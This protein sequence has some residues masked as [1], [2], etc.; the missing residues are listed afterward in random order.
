MGEVVGDA[1]HEAGLAF[2]GHTDNGDHARAKLTLGVIHKPAQILGRNVLQR[3][4]KELHRPKIADHRGCVGRR[5]PAKGKLALGIGELFFEL[6]ALIEKGGEPLDHLV[7][8]DFEQLRSLAHAGVLRGEIRACPLPSQRLDAADA[9]GNRA[10]AHDLEQADI[11]GAPHMGAAAKLDGI[12]VISLRAR[13]ALTHADDTDLF[14]IFLTEQRKR[15]FGDRL[16]GAHQMR[17]H[18]GVL[19]YHGVGKIFHRLDLGLRHRPRMGEVEAKPPRLDQRAL[20]GHVQPKHFAQRFVQEV[21][22]GMIGAR[23]SAAG[24]IDRKIDHLADLQGSSFEA[25]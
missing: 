16:V 17:L 15:A 24:M 4:G 14:A 6:A 7:G 22:G 20:L 9:G 3:A 1:D 11:A 12:S 21:G 25:A 2:L 5:T 10:L 18:G 8:A 13:R 19:Q 23:C